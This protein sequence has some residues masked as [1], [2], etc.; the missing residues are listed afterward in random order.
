MQRT[1][2]HIDTGREWR[3]GQQQALYLHEGLHRLDE[4][5]LMLCPPDSPM[6][7]RCKKRGLPVKAFSMRGEF[8]LLAV[9]RIIFEARGKGPVILQAHDAHALALIRL[10]APWIPCV[11]TIGVRRVDFHIGRNWFSR[12][13]YASA[14]I[15]R[16][17]C[18]SGAIRRVLESDGISSRRLTVIHSAIDP[19]RFAGIN[20]PPDFRERWRIPEDHLIVGTVAA[21]V[22]HKDYPNL[23]RAAAKVVRSYP[24]VTFMTVGSGRDKEEIERLAEKIGVVDHFRFTGQQAE[25][26]AFLKSFDLF[27]LASKQ[28][29][30]G[31]SVLDAMSVGLPVIGT[32][33]GG[34]PEMIDAGCDGLIVPRENASALSKA[35]LTLLNDPISRGTMAQNALDKAGMFSAKHMVE[36]YRTLYTR[37]FEH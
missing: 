6:L 15:N 35:I 16:V 18:I 25:V 9:G 8:D 23:I 19:N 22:G 14:W 31:T 20:P 12:Q 28:E 29:G 2:I 32:D 27:V 11:R 7:A 36:K 4:Q 1:I 34:I 37:L 33:A 30:L 3:G 10:A 21:F 5:S 17:V 24:N 13:K 26:G